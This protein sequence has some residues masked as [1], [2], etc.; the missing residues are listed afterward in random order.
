MDR[1]VRKN[2]K[3][4]GMVIVIWVWSKG[5]QNTKHLIPGST[6]HLPEQHRWLPCVRVNTTI[7]FSCSRTKRGD[8]GQS[9]GQSP[10]VQALVDVKHGFFT[11]GDTFEEAFSH[12]GS[13]ALDSQTWGQKPIIIV[14]ED[15]IPP[16]FRIW[17]SPDTQ[18]N[19]CRGAGDNP[20]YNSAHSSGSTTS[21]T[22]LS[23]P[24]LLFIMNR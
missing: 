21:V 7:L 10:F 16:Q 14:P 23:H 8:D 13:D 17:T 4:R 11:E 15:V 3:D 22:G 12:I 1:K 19:P 9:G 2:L 20:L 5:W 6:G 18:A 24:S